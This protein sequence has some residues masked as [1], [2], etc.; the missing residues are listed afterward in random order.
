M[1]SILFSVW[2]D[3]FQ[4]LNGFLN[5]DITVQVW[6]NWNNISWQERIKEV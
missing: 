1:F 5:K 2:E 6:K 4:S 3:V